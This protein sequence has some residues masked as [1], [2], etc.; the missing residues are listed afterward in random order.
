M[1][2]GEAGTIR[3]G[4]TVTVAEILILCRAFVRDAI[5]RRVLALLALCATTLALFFGAD[6]FATASPLAMRR[7]KIAAPA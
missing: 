2:S 3:F 4:Q 7:R 6:R 5:G 1:T